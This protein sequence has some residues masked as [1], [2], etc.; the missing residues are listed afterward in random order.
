MP[1][2]DVR[3]ISAAIL[4]RRGGM[5]GIGWSLQIANLFLAFVL[6]V[7]PQNVLQ[8]YGG[9]CGNTA[10]CTSTSFLRPVWERLRGPW[11]A[12]QETPQ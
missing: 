1:P 5:S 6:P 11:H 10:L 8:G 9:L 7:W 12:L 2:C 4:R 3:L